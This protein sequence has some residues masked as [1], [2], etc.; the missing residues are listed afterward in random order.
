M[1][2]DELVGQEFLFYG[3][4]NYMIKLDDTVYQ[5]E[6]DLDDGY[7]SIL[8]EITIVHP[9]SKGTFFR[10]PICIVKVIRDETGMNNGYILEDSEY[11]HTWLKFGTD[12]S[13][14]DYP[15]FYFNYTPMK[16]SSRNKP[17]SIPNH[18]IDSFD[19]LFDPRES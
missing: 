10:E 15:C 14:D 1:N 16:E 6:E 2:F 18:H 7:R 4:D 13:E 5:V 9:R 17:K 8:G 19:R 11:K 3:V 12:N